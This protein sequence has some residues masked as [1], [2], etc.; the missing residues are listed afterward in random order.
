MADP[1]SLSGRRPPQPMARPSFFDKVLGRGS[2]MEEFAKGRKEIIEE[3]R[4]EKRRLRH[5]MRRDRR[6]YELKL[7]RDKR[8]LYQEFGIRSSQRA[9]RE[10][11]NEAERSKLRKKAWVKINK[12]MREQQRAAEREIEK[13]RDRKIKEM[14]DSLREGVNQIPET[15]VHLDAAAYQQGRQASSPD[16]RLAA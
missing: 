8:E 15:S 16:Q 4:K 1:F 14:R 7:E 12:Q 13:A 11:L 3:S 2:Y 5:D 6:E 9:N 10:D